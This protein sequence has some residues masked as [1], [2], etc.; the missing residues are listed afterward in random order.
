VAF[1]INNRK[2]LSRYRPPPHRSLRPLPP[3]WAEH[4]DAMTRSPL[5]QFNVLSMLLHA[6]AIIL[7]G[8]PSG[9]SK[10]GRAMW[11]ALNVVIRG[12]LRE[13]KVEAPAPRAP[14]MPATPPKP[15]AIPERKPVFPVKRPVITDAS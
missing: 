6:M 9:G 2:P 13:E 4:E 11:G 15:R 5:A 14:T 12:P 10:E 3:R 8:A 1:V 7:F